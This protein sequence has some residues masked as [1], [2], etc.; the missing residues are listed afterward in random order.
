MNKLATCALLGLVAACGPVPEESTSDEL[1]TATLH[2]H[3]PDMPTAES[4]ADAARR[5]AEEAER[6]RA[7]GVTEPVYDQ[8]LADQ[9]GRTWETR[10]ELEAE[11]A[12]D[13]PSAK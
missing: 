3:N 10:A 6:M 5:V 12:Q 1:P 4:E 9:P 11:R 7:P 8:R 13:N 2:V